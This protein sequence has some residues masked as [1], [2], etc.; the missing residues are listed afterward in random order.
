MK[1]SILESSKYFL[2]CDFL[3]KY[4]LTNIFKK[5]SIKKIV[6]SFSLNN[7]ITSFS[8][9]EKLNFIDAFYLFYSNFSIYSKITF[10]LISSKKDKIEQFDSSLKV[11]LTKK[12]DLDFFIFKSIY[13]SKTKKSLNFIKKNSLIST[14]SINFKVPMNF[15]L[16]STTLDFD[17]E[18]F[19]R[20]NLILNNVLGLKNTKLFLENL[21]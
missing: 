21:F 7:L 17:T 13:A 20:V 14:T 9:N 1:K 10:A 12:F 18:N 11:I 8:T 16:N 5:P 3:N 19:F 2:K 4:H 6:L 15:L